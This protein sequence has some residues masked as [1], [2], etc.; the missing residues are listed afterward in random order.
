MQQLYKAT[1]N[2]PTH[3]RISRFDPKIVV[4][5]IRQHKILI[6]LSLNLLLA[7]FLRFYNL[8]TDP[9]GLHQDEAVNGVD[10]FALGHTLRDHHGNFLPPMLES[11]GDW[12]SPVVTYLT[13]PFVM[14][15]G[16]SIFSVRLPVALAGVASIWLMYL[17]VKRLTG[18]K[19]LA[20][21]ASFFLCIMPWHI[22]TSRW[23]TPPNIVTFFL[24]LAIYSFL[25]VSDGEPKI[26][27]FALVAV[28]AALLTYTYPTLKM[29]AP[30]LLASFGLMDLVK[31]LSW[32]QLFTKYLAI[33]L[34]YLV[35][36]API[37]LLTLLDPQKYNYRFNSISIFSLGG[38]PVAEFFSRYFSYYGLNFNFGE[39]VVAYNFLALFFYPGIIL[40]VYALFARKDFVISR[41][42]AAFLL[43]WL[44]LY[45]I[46]ASLTID[47]Y[48]NTRVLH[49]LPLLA[50]FSV[51]TIA[52]VSNLIRSKGLAIIFYVSI[53]VISS[54][55]LYIFGNLY[56][57]SYPAITA[58]AFQYGV[59]QYQE[60]LLANDARFSSVVIDPNNVNSPYIYYLFFSQKDPATYN[61]TELNSGRELKSGWEP[62]EKLGKYT[63]R[64]VTPTDLAGATEIYAVKDQE[65]KIWYQIF[66]N[67]DKWFVVQP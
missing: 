42:V 36:V 43:A 64:A 17:I 57:G 52:A 63:I 40:A 25:R 53:V 24:L 29:F 12:A 54:F 66:A 1:I 26:W 37:F 2:A 31:K 6:L 22:M 51:I 19:D 3:T 61:Y 62:V 47:Y 14:L 58:K 34:P 56:F 21:L 18:R 55:Y 48:Y 10:A 45:P 4:G 30:L 67:G 46:P 33:G 15:L 50:I 23:A 59:P 41:P 11:Y 5:F 20:L 39:G 16:L 13:V 7:F 35:M 65:N 44:V 28:C 8:T 60:Y 32:K 27:K 49:G 9:S 38:N